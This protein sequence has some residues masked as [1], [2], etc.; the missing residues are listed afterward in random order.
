MRR[1]V[2]TIVLALLIG[3]VSGALALA[4]DL[5]K[6]PPAKVL[7]QSPDSPGK[8]TFV[9][10]SHMGARPDCTQCHPKLFPI[11]KGAAASTASGRITH[12]KMEKGGYC[13][14]CHNAKAAFGF[15]DCTTC[16]K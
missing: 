15:D 7:A 4:Q 6:L 3:A 11:A 2:W 14:A 12:A 8:V 13:G 9:H 1:W 10:A 5:P 16:H